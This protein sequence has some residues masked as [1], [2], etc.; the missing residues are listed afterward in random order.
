MGAGNYVCASCPGTE[1][2]K[3]SLKNKFDD[4]TIE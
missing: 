4:M 2:L 1:L 3:V